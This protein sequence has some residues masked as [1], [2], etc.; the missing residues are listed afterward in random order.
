MNAEDRSTPT[1]CAICGAALT[2]DHVGTHRERPMNADD[3]ADKVAKEYAG[4]HGIDGPLFDLARRIAESIKQAEQEAFEEG[5][6]DGIERAAQE[7]DKWEN[8][9]MKQ[10]SKI[11][12]LPLTLR[13]GKEPK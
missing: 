11:R 3:R 12:A 2:M 1:G 7:A 5:Q 8:T 10:S 9:G 13:E 4:A 6:R